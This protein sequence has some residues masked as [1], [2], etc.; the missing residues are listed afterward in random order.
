MPRSSAEQ[1]A[2]QPRACLPVLNTT[3]SA[4]FERALV[5][6]V[7]PVGRAP[8]ARRAMVSR[9]S[10]TPRPHAPCA[11]GVGP[12]GGGGVAFVAITYPGRHDVMAAAWNGWLRLAAG[13][14]VIVSDAPDS[15][16]PVVVAR[17][18][19]LTSKTILGLR[20]LLERM[21]ESV[22]W[23]ARV[24]DDTAL[25]VTALGDA[26]SM[27][28][29]PAGRRLYTGGCCNSPAP[30]DA[31]RGCGTALDCGSMLP[32]VYACS[33]GGAVLSR[34]ALRLY[35]AHA[36]TCPRFG[37]TDPHGPSRADPD[38]LNIGQCL[39]RASNGSTECTLPWPGRES[40][41]DGARPWF[42]PFH[43]WSPNATNP[44][45]LALHHVSRAGHK[46]AYRALCGAAPGPTPPAA[47]SSARRQGSAHG[48]GRA[49]V[50]AVR[51]GSRGGRGAIRDH[52]QGAR[53]AGRVAA[54]HSQT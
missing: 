37:L 9:P 39:L 18:T 49:A 13:R 14:V 52:V 8:S 51:A 15:R 12:S 6:V 4:C 16:F 2:Q 32:N 46:R 43:T 34:E 45:F 41:R 36:G 1:V 19:R 11:R 20:T 40:G 24:D 31:G 29:N 10:G 23:F 17:D 48:G 26:L 50:A 54:K 21:D 47:G 42:T 5:A 28:G 35:A 7:R 22:K 27:F 38:D 25:N 30:S 53:G 3:L 33:N 44:N